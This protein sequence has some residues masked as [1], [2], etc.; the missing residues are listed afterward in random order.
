M[1][2]EN[3][4][5]RYYWLK[6]PS[7]YF[8]KL[9]QKKMKKQKN[10]KEMQIV[11]LRM[12]L[13]SIDKGG[14]IRYQGVYNSIEE[15]LAEEFDEDIEVIKATL[16]YLKE[17]NMI[18]VSD[19]FDCFIPE[20]LEHTGSEG[21]SAERVRKH[22]EKKKVLQCN[23]CV[24][25]SNEETEKE[26]EKEIEKKIDT[27]TETNSNNS[28]SASVSAPA[29][30]S[31]FSLD[32]L[33]E[34][35]KEHKV[36]LT[37]EGV[38][39]FY[40]EMRRTGWT[41]YKK[42]VEPDNIVKSLRGYSKYN[43][44]YHLGN[45][46]NGTRWKENAVYDNEVDGTNGAAEIVSSRHGITFVKTESEEE[47]IEKLQK[48]PFLKCAYSSSCKSWYIELRDDGICEEDCEC[49]EEDDDFFK[50]KGCTESSPRNQEETQQPKETN[51]DVKWFNGKKLIKIDG[52]WYE[53]CD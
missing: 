21:Y 15:E 25:L 38:K 40:E 18:S 2:T 43:G 50:S 14:Y 1:N 36:N 53:A 45:L 11:Y 33:L 7:A 5:K 51:P 16:E 13:A 9:E 49:G 26:T 4:P 3:A 30:A 19:N 34:I 12:M 35:V 20:A 23:T 46:L 47:L 42:K 28:A 6:L 48:H 29:T 24:T 31:L 44:K 32:E 10:G 37:K 22:R 39:A 17:N 8:N 52:E 41:L 27:E